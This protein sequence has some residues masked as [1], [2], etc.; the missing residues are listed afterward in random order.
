MRSHQTRGTRTARRVRR[1][2]SGLLTAALGAGLLVVLPTPA[3]RGG[4]SLY[5]SH[6]GSDHASFSANGAVFIDGTITF[7]DDCLG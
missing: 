6:N 3:Q 7:D 1:T 5:F 4:N 2:L